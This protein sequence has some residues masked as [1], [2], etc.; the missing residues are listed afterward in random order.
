MLKTNSGILG[1]IGKSQDITTLCP[2]LTRD[3][4]T[5]SADHKEL[6]CLMCLQFLAVIEFSIL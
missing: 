6:L 4:M 1:Q 5:A 3:A 2:H